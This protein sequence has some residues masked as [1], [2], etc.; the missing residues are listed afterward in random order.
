MVLELPLTGTFPGIGDSDKR[1]PIHDTEQPV[2]E[3][4][5]GLVLQPYYDIQGQVLGSRGLVFA[6]VLLGIRRG[7]EPDWLGYVSY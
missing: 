7:K 6:G 1:V 4:A 5:W 3:C 2:P